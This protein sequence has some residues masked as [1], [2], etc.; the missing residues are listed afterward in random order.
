[1]VLS[2]EILFAAAFC[3]VRVKNDKEIATH[4]HG[5][6]PTPGPR[7]VRSPSRPDD[8]PGERAS[9]LSILR[10]REAA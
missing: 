3:G 8:R 10:P 4:T 6:L 5:Q 9:H 2:T 7:S 1:M